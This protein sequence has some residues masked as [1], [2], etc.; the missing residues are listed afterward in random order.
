MR[1]AVLCAALAAALGPSG[2]G[3]QSLM[4]TEADAL[5]RLSTNSPRVRAIRAAIDIARVDVLTAERWPNPRLTIDR[6]SVGGVTEY[7]TMVAQPLPITGRRRFEVQAASALVSASSSRADDEV[8]RLRAD[9]RLAFAQLAA[10][11]A[12]E[13]ELADA[14]DRLARA[15]RHPRPTRNGGRRGRVRSA[16]RRTRDS[17]RRNGP[18]HRHDRSRPRAGDTRGFLRG[19]GRPVA[20]RG[21][22]GSQSS[23]RIPR[24]D[25][26]LEQAESIRGELL[27]LQNEVD[28][29]GFAARAADRRR[30]PEPE[31]VAGTKSS[32]FGAGDIGSVVMVHAAI[33]LFD[34]ARPERAL[35]AARAAQAEARAEAFRVV[36]RGEVAALREA[37]HSAAGGGRS[38]SRRG[39]E[40]RRPDRADR[41]GQLRRRR[42]RH[43]RTARR[44]P[45]RRVGARAPGDA[46]SR[47]TAG[48][49]RA[50]IRH[51]LGDAVM[52]PT[53]FM[54]CVAL[55]S[56]IT[57]TACSRDDAPAEG[58][59][60]ANAGRHALDGQD[61]AVHGVPAARRWSRGALRRASDQAR[62]L[63]AGQRGAGEGRVHAGVG[64]C[65]RRCS[66]GRR[67][68][69]RV[70][71]ASKTCRRR[72][73]ATAG[74]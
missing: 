71:S 13:R 57:L 16:P 66:R 3:A 44:L 15:G 47:G 42:A 38:V 28:A 50:R 55:L 73:V 7:I 10:A 58:A 46:R 14:R 11:Q 31:I 33:P 65:S 48:R 19:R 68:R 26:L 52:R 30:L 72:R 69:G 53:R 54:T 37:V 45:H 23:D 40:Q 59:E 61:R 4:L 27:A 36:L 1:R 9:L 60:P 74:R 43:P 34:R 29:A 39:R 2:V 64:R 49:D 35:A 25:A 56:A 8:R 17:R 67:H 21:R 32:T 63:Q 24:L 70:R 51:R 12:R 5:A 22:R 62:G 18:G 41:A 6:E 20:T